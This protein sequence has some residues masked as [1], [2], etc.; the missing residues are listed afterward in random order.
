M[1]GKHIFNVIRQV[2]ILKAGQG[3]PIMQFVL[4]LDTIIL[5][6]YASLSTFIKK[7]FFKEDRDT[8]R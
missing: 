1:C 8:E 2:I 7:D 3:K 4:L 6:L 5:I